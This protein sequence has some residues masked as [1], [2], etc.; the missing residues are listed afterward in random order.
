M[1]ITEEF[2]EKT[3]MREL[4]AFLI[5]LAGLD[6]EDDHSD[7]VSAVYLDIAIKDAERILRTG[8]LF[9]EGPGKDRILKRRG[10]VNED[11]KD[12]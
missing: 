10:Q 3:D 11:A 6:S 8:R 9:P 4:Q 12:R 2:K 5:W 7:Y 1:M